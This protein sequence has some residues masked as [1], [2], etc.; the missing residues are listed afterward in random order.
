ML[1]RWISVGLLLGNLL[2]AEGFSLLD[3]RLSSLKTEEMVDLHRYRGKPLYIT[4][5]KSEC[6]WCGKQLAAFE[7]LMKKG[8]GAKI[9]VVAVALGGDTGRLRAMA[10]QVRFAGVLASDRLLNDIGGVRVTPYTLV[11][12]A[13][14]N[15]KTKIVGYQ[16]SDQLVKLINLKENKR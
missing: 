7:T 3:Y 5:Y 12:D 6:S 9:N 14:G 2:Q 15:F 10:R 13:E 16:S 11:T 4:F 8:Y 1:R